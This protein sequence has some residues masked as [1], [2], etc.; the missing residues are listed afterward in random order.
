MDADADRDLSFS[1]AEDDLT[2]GV[3]VIPLVADGAR[4]GGRRTVLASSRARAT[5]GKLAI[6]LVLRPRLGKRAA[7]EE[8]APCGRRLSYYYFA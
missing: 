6:A 3:T 5:C 7:V 4:R 1:K 8:S 2:A